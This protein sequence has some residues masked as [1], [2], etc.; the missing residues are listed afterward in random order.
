M[1]TLIGVTVVFGWIAIGLY[2]AV[3]A[4]GKSGHKGLNTFDFFLPD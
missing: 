3:I 2:T 4:S 1:D